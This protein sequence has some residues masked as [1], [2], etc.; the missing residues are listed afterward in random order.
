MPLSDGA[1]HWMAILA[2]DQYAHLLADRLPRA[3]IVTTPREAH[4][5]LDANRIPVLAPARWLQEADPLPHSWDVTSDSIA[6]WVAEQVGADRLLLVKP[7]G[8]DG[9]AL[10]DAHFPRALP[11]RVEAVVIAGD[12]LAALRSALRH[13][14]GSS[15]L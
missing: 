2:M 8:A 6:A 10:V 15:E 12:R 5:A 3:R 11:D 4:H 13:A 14:P 1:A 9:P 7:S